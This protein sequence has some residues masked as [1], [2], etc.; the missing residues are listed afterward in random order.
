MLDGP[1]TICRVR[2]RLPLGRAVRRIKG[3]SPRAV[4]V[5][6]R[7]REVQAM[8]MSLRFGV[9]VAAACCLLLVA[10][11]MTEAHAAGASN[12]TFAGAT[13]SGGTIAPGSYSSL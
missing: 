9:A 7:D 10:G 1:R 3:E 6:D 8:R 12:H 11:G 13:C 2:S 4:N 5:R